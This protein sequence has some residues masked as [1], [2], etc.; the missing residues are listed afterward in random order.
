MMSSG[1]ITS[2]FYM[3]NQAWINATYRTSKS[4]LQEL[5]QACV[6]ERDFEGF[7]FR[8]GPNTAAVTPAVSLED[9]VI[10]DILSVGDNMGL[11]VNRD[12]IDELVG[13]H[14]AELIMKQQQDL[15]KE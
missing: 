6:P 9:T 5:W 7:Q 2:A 4:A 14:S 10:D 15:V 11:E 3:I 1:K 8:A 13:S 12:N